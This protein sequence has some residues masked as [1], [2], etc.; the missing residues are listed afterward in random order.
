[1]KI[2]QSCKLTVFI[3]VL[4]FFISASF[5]NQVRAEEGVPEKG[6]QIS[7]TKFDSDLKPGDI[8][9]LTVN[10]K[11]YSKET[12]HNIKVEIEDIFIKD[13]GSSKPQYLNHE[14]S[15]NLKVYDVANWIEADDEFILGPNEAKNVEIKITIPENV[16]TGSYYGAIVFKTIINSKGDQ[17]EGGNRAE[18]Q[19]YYG[20]RVPLFNA[21]HG[22]ETAKFEGK[23][24]EFFPGHDIFFWIANQ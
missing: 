3:L 19:E 9:K 24:L 16:P 21:I 11:N 13:D 18:I 5:F 22:K 4:T 12:S 7:P 15:H 17:Q 1:M 23:M 14:E 10:V 8:K 2:F 6:L 20:A